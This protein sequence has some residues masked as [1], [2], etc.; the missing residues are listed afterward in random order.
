MKNISR[1]IPGRAAKPRFRPTR[2]I[3]HDE[4]LVDGSDEKIRRVLFLMR[5][6]SERLAL[7][8][9]TI[10]RTVGLTGNQYTILLAIAHAPG[11]VGVTVREVARYTLMASTHVTTQVGALSRK[12]LVQKQ[13]HGHDRRSV[14]L[15]LMPQGEKVMKQIAAL[16]REF[17]DS[18]FVGISR[19]SLLA[20]ADFLEQVAANSERALPLLKHARMPTQASRRLTTTR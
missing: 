14:L 3:S 5:L 12:R 13:P 4:M 17:N 16:R 19:A 15:S 2:S 6:A 1:P 7:F 8:R 10:A 11:D 20:A 9:E 18:F